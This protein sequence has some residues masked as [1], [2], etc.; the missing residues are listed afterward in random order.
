M[1]ASNK[2]FLKVCYLLITTLILLFW[3][4][5][6]SINAYWVQ[7]YHK[8]SPLSVLDNNSVWQLGGEITAFLG[9]QLNLAQDKASI[10]NEEWVGVFNERLNN[11]NDL[12]LPDTTPIDQPLELVINTEAV[13]EKIQPFIFPQ[14]PFIQLLPLGTI[15]NNRVTFNS[16]MLVVNKPTNAEQLDVTPAVV[17]DTRFLIEKG[18]KVFFVGDSLMQGVAPHAMR[19]L[20]RQHGI[21]SINLSKQSTGLSYPR[22]YN[23]PQVAHETFA[24]NPEIKLMVVFMGPNDPWDFPVVRGKKFLKFNTPEWQGVY[25]TRVQQLLNAATEHGAQVL[26]IGIPN[27]KAPR[28]NTG[29]IELNKIYQSQVTIA[30]QRYIPSNDVLGMDDDRFV[31][32]MRIPNRGNVTLRTDD[33]VHF[34]I[35]GQKR[36]ADKIISLL[37]FDDAMDVTKQ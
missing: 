19:T 24:K 26:W 34:T 22:F 23:W 13:F 29:I 18:Q 37:R 12:S 27:M 6:R 10:T 30:G 16:S 14:Q 4:Q 5:Q 8:D 25:R 1:M 9:E 28:L 32:F 17:E 36:I 2:R 20:L 15:D 21:E 3:L 11:I 35:I 31:K 7:T 33:G